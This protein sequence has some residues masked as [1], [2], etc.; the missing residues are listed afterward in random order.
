MFYDVLKEY[1][2]CSPRYISYALFPFQDLFSCKC[3]S[4]ILETTLIQLKFMKLENCFFLAFVVKHEHSLKPWLELTTEWENFHF[5]C[6]RSSK[7][8]TRSDFYPQKLLVK[9]DWINI[10]FVRRKG[11]FKLL[12]LFQ[13]FDKSLEAGH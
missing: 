11:N 6:H 3:I 1:V 2:A 4:H 13:S 12:N 8:S 5:L 7:Q 9:Q 10:G